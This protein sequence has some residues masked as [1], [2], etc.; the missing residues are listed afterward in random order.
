MRLDQRAGAC[1]SPGALRRNDGQRQHEE[2]SAARRRRSA[3][4]L[5]Q[6]AA[7]GAWN[8]WASDGIAIVAAAS[9]G[10]RRD[11]AGPARVEAL[12]AVLEPADEEGDAE[13]EHA[14]REDRADERRLDDVDEPLVQSEE[15]D[16]ELRQ[17]AEGGLDDA[18]AARAEP[19]AQLL[20]R[21]SD[22]A[23][24]R[25][26]RGGSDEKRQYGSEPGEVADRGDQDERRQLR[27][28]RSGRAGSLGQ[29]PTNLSSLVS[30]VR[31]R[32]ESAEIRN[33]PSF[34]RR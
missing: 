6:C 7:A 30:G 33:K 20:G 27:R 15:R 1:S 14:V 2:R 12:R 19:R 16:E 32:S 34:S 17:V 24:E 5:R 29:E 23:G 11:Q 3:T 18:G 13:H 21:R 31:L 10:Q 26:E 28:S 25:G 8:A 22:R 9:D 4:A